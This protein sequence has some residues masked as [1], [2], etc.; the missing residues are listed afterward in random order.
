MAKTLDHVH[1]LR[2]FKYSNGTKIYFCTLDCGYKI[3]VPLAL[4][5]TSICNICGQPFTMNEY[6]IKLAK[7]H[8]NTCG[9]MKVEVNGEAR[10]VS[11]NRPQPAM[12]ELAHDKVDSLKERLGKVVQM[13]KDEEL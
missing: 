8:C 3:E 9:K 11:K 10:F 7:P 4:G 12:A 5:K 2:R 1:R 13:A 6:S